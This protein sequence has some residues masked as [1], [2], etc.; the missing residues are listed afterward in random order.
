MDV[1]KHETNR[2]TSWVKKGCT[3]NG[4]NK[5]DYVLFRERVSLTE[6]RQWLTNTNK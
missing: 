2:G 6:T 1:R 3:K 4:D 5:L